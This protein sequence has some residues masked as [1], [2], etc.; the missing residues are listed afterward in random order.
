MPQPLNRLQAFYQA[1]IEQNDACAHFATFIT[2]DEEGQPASRIVTLRALDENGIVL[3]VNAHSPKI[4]HWQA[5][6]K[7]ELSG[8]WPLQMVQYRLRGQASLGQCEATRRDWQNRS[9]AGQ[10]PDLY[11]QLARPQSSPLPS[12]EVL[13]AEAEALRQNLPAQVETPPGVCVLTLR[14]EF[15]EI[16]HAS[17]ADRLHDRRIYRR[18]AGADWESTILV[19]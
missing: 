9:R 6:G 2:V 14:P 5:N 19:P 15:V 17:L 16:G 3:K 18:Q 11:H 4:R 10:L 8:F 12:R 13:L 1:A 7:W